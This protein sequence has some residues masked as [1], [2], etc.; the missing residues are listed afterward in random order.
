MS[1]RRGGSLPRV[2][3]SMSSVL[4][5]QASAPAHPLS[6]S[7]KVLICTP[8]YGGHMIAPFVRSLIASLDTLRDADITAGWLHHP[9]SGLIGWAR[10]D[11]AAQFLAEEGSTHLVFIDSDIE[12]QPDDLLRLLRHD[13]DIAVGLYAYRSESRDGSPAYCAPV[14]SPDGG[15]VRKP[16]TG[17]VEVYAAGAGF[18]AI[19]R[20]ALTRIMA[21]YPDD[22]I[23]NP[24]AGLPASAALWA[25][26][27]F[28][29]TMNQEGKL[30]SE[31]VSFFM[32]WRNLG[33]KVW[34]DPT[35]KLKHHGTCAFELDPMTMLTPAPRVDEAA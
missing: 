9:N 7:G 11:L 35:I 17:L 16:R 10:N 2:M 4:R 27:F 5:R 18:L 22:K 34:L 33:G 8:T 21:A 20:E 3:P 29:V 25:F 32:R 23:K 31:D 26:N 24:T 12:W 6:G 14:R 28:P 15:I 19:R 13:V 1:K 30:M